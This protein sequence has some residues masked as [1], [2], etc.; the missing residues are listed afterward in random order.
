SGLQSCQSV[1]L[2]NKNNCN[3]AH[4]QHKDENEA[5]SLTSSRVYILR[6]I[7]CGARTYHSQNKVLVR[8][9]CIFSGSRKQ[10]VAPVNQSY[11]HTQKSH[12]PVKRKAYKI[13][14]KTRH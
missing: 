3:R 4:S 7:Q 11:T 12:V 1:Y 14:I 10:S 9:S 13:I 8:A 2:F 5:I 6:F